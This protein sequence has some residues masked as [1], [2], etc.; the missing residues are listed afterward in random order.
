MRRNGI[1]FGFQER[2][3]GQK[4]RLRP[5][6]LEAKVGIYLTKPARVELLLFGGIVGGHSPYMTLRSS[7]WADVR[8]NRSSRFLFCQQKCSRSYGQR[9]TGTMLKRKGTRPLWLLSGEK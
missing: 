9:T 2:D 1:H 5:N 6:R 7:W 8:S 4:Y 3:R